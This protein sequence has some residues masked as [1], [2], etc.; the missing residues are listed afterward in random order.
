MCRKGSV[1]QK[2]FQQHQIPCFRLLSNKMDYPSLSLSIESIQNAFK[3]KQPKT[4]ISIQSLTKKDFQLKESTLQACEQCSH[5]AS[6][7][8][9]LQYHIMTKH[10]VK[11]DKCNVCDYSHGDPRKMKTHYKWEHQNIMHTCNQC[12]FKTPKSETLRSHILYK[13][14]ELKVKCVDCDYSHPAS[15]KVKAHH[16]Q[17]HLGIKRLERRIFCRQGDCQYLGMEN[18]PESEHNLLYCEECEYTTQASSYLKIHIQNAHTPGDGLLVKCKQCDY[19]TPWSSCM[20]RHKVNKHMDEQTKQKHIN[21]KKCTFENCLFKTAMPVVLKRH[22]ESKH[23][24]IVHFRC[25]YMNCAYVTDDKKTFKRHTGTHNKAFICN[26]CKKVF[27][28]PKAL[29]NHMRNIH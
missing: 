3:V 22:V 5:Q 1:L 19:K 23:E 2:T 18:C 9:T 17:V 21:W 29:K 13:H 26:Y 14:S 6:N 12:E 10:F 20:T 25:K 11:K 27:A 28:I 7:S 16:R 15:G 8:Q 4:N 24:G